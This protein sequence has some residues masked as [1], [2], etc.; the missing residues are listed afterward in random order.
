[1]IRFFVPGIPK[2]TQTGSVI[3]VNGRAIP[4]RRNTGADITKHLDWTGWCR[5]HGMSNRPYTP[6]TGPLGAMFTVRMPRPKKPGVH[7]EWA[8]SGPDAEN[9]LKAPKDA[10][11]DVLYLDD[12]QILVEVLRK[13]YERVGEGPGLEVKVWELQRPV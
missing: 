12:K 8:M 3:W 9:V 10:W 13:G 7:G 1:M 4:S 5:L 11:Q 6:L 2:S